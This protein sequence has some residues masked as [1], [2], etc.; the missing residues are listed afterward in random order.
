MRLGAAV[1]SGEA[2]FVTPRRELLVVDADLP[3]D[4]ARAADVLSSFDLLM[5]AADRAGVPH[6]A[7]ASGRPGHRHGYLVAGS[8]A[9]RA[10]LERWCRERGLDVRTQGV[11]PPGA[12]HR[13]TAQMATELVDLTRAEV[14]HAVAVLT[15]P[16]DGDAVARLAADVCPLALPGRVLVA[17]RHGH[18]HAGY[19][20][21][22]HARMALAVAV[23]ARGGSLGL[24]EAILRDESTP[25]GATFRGRP[26][27]WQRAEL[28]RI[29]G[30]AGQW[31]GAAGRRRDAGLDDVSAAARAWRWAGIS[32]GSDLAVLEHL[33]RIAHRVR[34]RV[35]GAALVDVAVGAG[36]SPD[37]ARAAVRRLAA[38]GWL[39]VVSHETAR[40]TRTYELRV[41]AGAAVAGPG[42]PPAEED[43]VGDLGADLARRG[44]LGKVTMRVARTITSSPGHTTAT[45]S[46]A[47][48]MTG[49]A[50]R[51]HLRKLVA[52]GIVERGLR[53]W[54]P[55][56]PSDVLAV[57]A[58]AFRVAGT[59][60]RQREQVERDRWVR[61]EA[62]RAFVRLRRRTLAPPP[63]PPAAAA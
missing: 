16:V 42:G 60:E 13:L 57:L 9:Q 24:V 2:F 10:R 7:V 53:G 39:R 48:V 27:A 12:P 49:A 54:F 59:R 33:S 19:D 44:A 18:A 38:A 8:G 58:Q 14:S 45:L 29:W 61:A 1:S 4:P 62:R 55:H 23:R 31:I 11:R 37:T 46:R 32:G 35:V 6:L 20:S 63:G 3:E 30:K 40:T 52:A 36:I 15:A 47:L 50:V 17:V 56:G 26:V 34:S 25:L 51:Y 5:E 28:E 21:P 41:P 43:T 22:S